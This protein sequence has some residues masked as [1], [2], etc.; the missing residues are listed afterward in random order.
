MFYIGD[1]L[2]SDN[3]NGTFT[4]WF[5]KAVKHFI[6]ENFVLVYNPYFGRL[7]NP[8]EINKPLKY[9]EKLEKEE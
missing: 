7:S 3:K 9:K 2:I 5:N 4:P 1:I 8:L 6:N